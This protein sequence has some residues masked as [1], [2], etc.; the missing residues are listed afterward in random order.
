MR[1]AAGG[2]YTDGRPIIYTFFFIVLQALSG[3]KSRVRIQ[4]SLA[5][6]IIVLRQPFLFRG[7][8]KGVHCF[9]W[10]L[11]ACRGYNKF[12]SSVQGQET[13]TAFTIAGTYLRIDFTNGV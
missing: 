2:L 4:L 5:P 13:G 3:N 1:R 6:W 8:S 12:A 7:S 9:L 10:D 11:P